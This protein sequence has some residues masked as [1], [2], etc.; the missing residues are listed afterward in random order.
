V[1]D[2]V[3]ALLVGCGAIS[4]TWL[5]ALKLIPEVELVG[6]VD[7]NEAQARSRAAEF[8]LT[9]LP[10]GSDLKTLLQDT[11]PDAVFDCTVPEA[12]Y[13]VTLTALAAGC[14]VLGEKPI[15]DDPAK[16]REMVAAAERSGRVYA[17][18]QNRRFD[19]N[20]R[21][22]KG[23]LRHP[24]L[25]R[26]TTVHSDFFVGAHFGGFREEMKHVL[27]KD[28]AI[29][30]FDAA[31]SLTGEDPVSVYCHEWNP[32]GSW[33]AHGA[34]A[35]AVF[36]M[37]GGVVFTY[38]GSWSAEGFRTPW[39]SEWRVLGERGSVR[40]DG[41]A[42]IAGE[43]VAETSGLLSTYRALELL[44][45]ESVKTLEG[46]AGVIQD[47]VRALQTGGT[48]ETICTDNLKSL[49]M[50]FGAVESAETGQR[51]DIGSNEGKT[52]SNEGKGEEC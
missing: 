5:E 7:L 47:F 16:A 33:Y 25:G 45:E 49:E 1:A 3:R 30:T 48:P 10:T 9:H 29:H 28:M 4:Q 35:V 32:P 39:E 27:L 14:H 34:S 2:P 21:R 41:E 46:H 24:D 38:R 50:V 13:D 36:E 15:S 23:L 44:P 42:G 40:W 22:V 6:L 51:V 26:I 17:V 11:A 52:M 12:H 31:R 8:G 19:R 37:T 20:L 43:V 18:I